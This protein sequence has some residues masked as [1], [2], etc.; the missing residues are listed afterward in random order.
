MAGAVGLALAD[1]P[2]LRPEI[3][4]AR[5]WT[6][7]GIQ[8]FND[9]K[10]VLNGA[11]SGSSTLKA[12]ATGGGTVTLPTGTGTLSFLDP[13]APNSWTGAQ[14]FGPVIGGTNSQSGTTYTLAAT[15]CGKTLIFTNSSAVTLTTL[16]S[17][18]V[19]CSI[20]VEQ[21]GTGQV[22]IANGSGAT[23]GSSHSFTK[24]YGQKAIIG[25]FVD[26]NSGGSAANFNI[27]GDGA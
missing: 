26:E 8:S 19:G 23:S 21:K 10:L 13:T 12:P 27:T 22:T 1:T 3:F 4:I 14:T 16:N 6:W 7:S 18:V 20:A 25:L 11:T 2:A 9:A 17:L 24:T 15:D 5:A